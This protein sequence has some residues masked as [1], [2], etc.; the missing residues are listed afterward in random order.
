MSETAGRRSAHGPIFVVSGAS[1]ESGERLVRT[2]LAQFENPDMPIEIVRG[3]RR[4][5]QIEAV[6]RRAAKSSGMVF[7]TLV[8]ARRRRALTDAA[9]S[10]NVVAVDLIGHVLSRLS[11]ALQQAPQGR[12]GLYRELHEENIKRIEAMGFAVAHD[13]GARPE[14]LSHADIVLLGVSRVG[15]TPL[16]MYLAMRG[17]KVANIPLV[18]E[19]APPEELIDVEDTKIVGLTV[20]PG[21]LK[22]HRRERGMRLG[23]GRLS[24]Y[25][26]G[27]TLIKE[28]NFAQHWCRKRRVPVLD[29]TAKPIEEIADEV[30]ATVTR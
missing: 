25:A 14:G 29:V 2:A 6:V 15:K 18:P 20:D 16:S 5:R 13:D 8:D 3:V 26:D 19:V 7:H 21:Q 9:R 22:L 12:P 23:A 10:A 27:E 28:V 4:K 30:V 24:S 1:G 11:E 17:W